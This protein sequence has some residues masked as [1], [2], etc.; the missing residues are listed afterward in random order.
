MP[1][2]SS[3]SLDLVSCSGLGPATTAITQTSP[4]RCIAC[5]TEHACTNRSTKIAIA[6]VCP[7]AGNLAPD[8]VVHHVQVDVVAL[9]QLVVAQCAHE[10]A[11]IKG[12]VTTV[13]T[14]RLEPRKTWPGVLGSG[15]AADKPAPA[16]AQPVLSDP[17]Y[18]P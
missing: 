10:P 1:V 13:T 2:Y 17:I 9:L 6:H 12:Y 11:G 3:L 18:L 14:A 15:V 8:V 16:A 4:C 5:S 7:L